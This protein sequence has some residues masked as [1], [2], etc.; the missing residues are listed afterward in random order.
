M[1]RESVPSIPDSAVP[2]S[3]PAPAEEW[4]FDYSTVTGYF[5]QDEKD[6]DPATFDFKTHAFG[7]IPRPY[8]TDSSA[9]SSAHS[10]WARFTHYLSTLNAATPEFTSYRL[11]FLGRHGQG[12]HNVAESFYGTE[13]WDCYYS[14]LDGNETV[15][16]SDAHLT[17]IGQ[18]QAGEA[19]DT[20]VKTVKEQGIQTPQS[21]YVSPLDR[22]IETCDITFDGVSDFKNVKRTVKEML[23]EGN[24]VHT[25]DRRSSRAHIAKRWPRYEI[26]EG[27]SEEDELWKAELRESIPALEQRLKGLLDDVFEHDDNTWISMTAHSGTIMAI[28]SV[29]GHRKF[30]LQTGGVIPVLVKVEKKEGKRKEGEVEPWRPKPDCP[31]GSDPESL[32]KDERMMV[33]RSFEEYYRGLGLEETKDPRNPL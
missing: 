31:E 16:W 10:D 29:V 19:H 24:G 21:F 13:L 1:M 30:P 17:S 25:C 22:A 15:S 23:R 26:E 27:F 14:T 18:T 6:T 32:G 20:W 8:D 33:A 2:P 28:L 11:L 7:L 5:M 3:H 9:P 4:H 12:F